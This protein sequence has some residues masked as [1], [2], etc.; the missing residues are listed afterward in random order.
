MVGSSV[1]EGGIYNTVNFNVYHYGSNNPIKYI[2]PNGKNTYLIIWATSDDGVGHAGFAIDNYKDDGSGNMIPDGTI[3]YYDLWPGI[4]V[5]QNNVGE[6]VPGFYGVYNNL[7]KENLID[8]DPSRNKDKI[9]DG[10]IEF[11]NEFEQDNKTK[12][13][14]EKFMTSSDKYNGKSRNCS[15]MASVGVEGSTGKKMGKENCFGI[16]CTTP[17]QLFND[18]KKENNAKILK[19][20]GDK[21]NYKFNE[22]I[23][24]GIDTKVREALRNYLQY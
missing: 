4:D 1:G 18:S 16:I 11:S 2:D 10:V 15:D 5:D 13:K 6:D 3:T 8:T 12:I 19:N 14:L 23:K 21:I 17:N 20:P 22:K 7:L 24:Q 9:P